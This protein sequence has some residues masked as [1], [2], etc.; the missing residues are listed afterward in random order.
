MIKNVVYKLL[1]KHNDKLLCSRR[2]WRY[3]REVIRIC[4]SKR[5]RQHN[6]QN[7]KDKMTNN[8]LQNIHMKLKIE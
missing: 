7:K 8:D 1:I 2:V 5:N 3:Q 4:K 6:G